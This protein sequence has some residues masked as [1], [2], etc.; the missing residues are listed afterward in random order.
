MASKDKSRSIGKNIYIGLVFLFLY[1]PIIVVV[2]FYFNTSKM[3]ILFEGFTTEW[4]H[5]MFYN[6]TLMEALTN[7][8]IVGVV[9]T[10]VAT[11]I[12]TLGAYAL[13]KYEFP[14]K[15][16]LDRVLYIPVVIP[17]VVLGIS[18]LAVY[19]IL[20]IELSLLT[21]I[22]AHITFCIPFVLLTMRA[23]IAGLDGALE[24]AAMDLG[25]RPFVAF[26]KVILPLL[27]PGITSGAMLSFTLSL[28][29]VIISF[30]TSGPASTTLPLK[31]YA[32]VKTGVTPEVNALSTMIMLV[33]ITIVLIIAGIQVKKL[34]KMEN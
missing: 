6:R 29:D 20:N 24:E 9:S 16:M 25:A 17:E 10:L 2:I 8:L 7:S 11:I 31:V 3:N 22:F 18:L 15:K 30:F 32:M 13:Y 4:Y 28:D 33:M 19:S 26:Y 34:K 27:V 12:G 5:T 23:R 14:G 1:I 21:I